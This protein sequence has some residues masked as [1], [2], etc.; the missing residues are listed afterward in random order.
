[1]SD[2][3]ALGA[4]RETR[5]STSVPASHIEP[6]SVFVRSPTASEPRARNPAEAL[7]LAATP[8]RRADRECGRPQSRHDA[9]DL[10]FRLIRTMFRQVQTYTRFICVSEHH[11]SQ[12]DA[13]TM[14]CRVAVRTERRAR[15]SRKLRTQPSLSFYL[16]FAVAVARY[17]SPGV[18]I[19]RSARRS[20]A[21]NDAALAGD[22]GAHRTAELVRARARAHSAQE[23]FSG[24]HCSHP[25]PPK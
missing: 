16:K 22:G 14:Q 10:C 8:R 21:L 2:C 13:G 20:C 23:H 3:A 15:R 6:T 9:R 7:S 18:K 24:N 19:H 12:S 1:M 4:T 5:P 11:E 25:P 17:I